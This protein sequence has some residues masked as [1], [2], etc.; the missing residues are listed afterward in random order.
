MDH[1]VLRSRRRRHSPLF[2]DIF[3]DAAL[4][5]AP[6]PCRKWGSHRL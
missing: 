2:F 6:G 4:T 3:A 5:L 1:P